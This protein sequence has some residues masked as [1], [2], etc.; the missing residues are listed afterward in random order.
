MKEKNGKDQIAEIAEIIA[1]VG[2]VHVD[3]SNL[4]ND[5]SNS[6]SELNSNESPTQP[7]SV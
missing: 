3:G 6:R 5:R 7:T 4:R 2:C 1:F